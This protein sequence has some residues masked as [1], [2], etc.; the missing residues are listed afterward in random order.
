MI[1]LL[2][3]R[4]SV[5]LMTEHTLHVVTKYYHQNIK[6]LIAAR[7]KKSEIVSNQ[8]IKLLHVT[9]SDK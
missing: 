3:N 2:T 8:K 4:Y 1:E 6:I 5:R 9:K 7:Q